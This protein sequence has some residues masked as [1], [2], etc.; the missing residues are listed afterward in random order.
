MC[1]C[2]SINSRINYWLKLLSETHV[3]WSM[4]YLFMYTTKSITLKKSIYHDKVIFV[5]MLLSNNLEWSIILHFALNNC[6]IANHVILYN[7]RGLSADVINVY[8]SLCILDTLK[9]L[10]EHQFSEVV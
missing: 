6:N 10:M 4:S 3:L 5:D 9:E 2:D 8:M 7:V 1:E